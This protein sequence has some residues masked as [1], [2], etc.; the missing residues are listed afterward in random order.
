MKKSII[1]LSLAGAVLASCG[2]GDQQ[3][4]SMNPFFEAYNTPFEVPPFDK[5]K[6]EHFAP[7]LREGMRLHQEEIDAIVNNPEQPTFANTI[8]AMENSGELLAKVS[9]V[10]GNLNSANT[11]DELQAIAREMAPELSKHSDNINLN[12]QLFERVKQVWE[13]KDSFSLNAEQHKLLE[14]SYKSF[15]RNGA[16]L[17]DSD[18]EKLREINSKLSVLSLQFG[19]NVLAETNAYKLFIDNE[20][21]LSGLPQELRDVAFQDAEMAG[22]EEK[23]LF[24]LQNPSVMPFLQ[25][26]DNRDLRKEIWEAYK[27]RG[28]QGNDKDN[29]EI[30]IEMANLR[31]EKANLLG[32]ATHADYVLEESMAKNPQNVQ[33]LLNQLWTPALAKAKK[34]RDEMQAMIAAEG[35]DFQLEPWD[36]RYYEEKLRVQKFD[37]D[38]QEVKPYFALDKVQEGVFMVVNKLWG[39]TFSEITNIPTYHPEA[40]AYEVKEADGSHVGVLYMD[41]HPRASKRGGAW[42]TSYRPQK[43]VNGERKAPVISIVC[44]FS[45]PT[46]NAP[47]LLTFDEVTTFFHEFGHALHG[48]LSNVQYRSL[49]GTSV[50]RDLVELPSQIMENWATEPEVMKQYAFHYQTGEVIPDA[51][52]EKL[53][54]SGTFGQ[55][56]GTTEYLAASFLDMDYHSRTTP[57]EVGAAEFENASM[58]NIGLI[59]EI[60]PRYRSTYFQHI[61]SG[62]YSS[63]YYS[64]IWSGVLDTDAFQAFK[65]T[66]L[67]N[68]EKALAFRREILERGGTDEP[69]N[70]YVNFRGAEPKIDAL[71]KKR[72]LDQAAV[73]RTK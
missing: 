10:F 35:K 7:A 4:D 2:V 47:A 32:Y 42:M 45:K 61:F 24:T 65:E 14:K 41:F 50:P 67:F 64:Y 5:I 12:A 43:K 15:V 21:D 62:G 58:N 39:L 53:Q 60:I 13:N 59:D 26:A 18:K 37:L 56:F 36:W 72:G 51:L 31:L 71:L 63:G 46:G 20:A 38:V 17:N 28:D 40:K 33:Q 49:A 55:G 57:I 66:E 27:N 8:E 25:Y 30:L 3:S 73:D 44:N 52:I 23:Y 6:N 34:E 70:M 22:E 48:L 69:M 54:K 68:Q 19:Q 29:N 1:A 16:N 9:I 11:S